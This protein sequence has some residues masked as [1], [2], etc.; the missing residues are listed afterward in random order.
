MADNEAIAPISGTKKPPQR[1]HN[2]TRIRVTLLY[3]RETPSPNGHGKNW[4]KFAFTAIQ[5]LYS[6][7]LHT[8][9]GQTRL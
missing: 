3:R 7:P 2:Q 5:P 8:F 9:S 1:W 4:A 6:D